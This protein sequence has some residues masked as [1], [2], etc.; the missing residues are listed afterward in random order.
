MSALSPSTRSVQARRNLASAKE[1]SMKLVGYMRVASAEVNPEE[2]FTEHEKYLADY[3]AANGHEVVAHGENAGG[4]D[5]QERPGL[6]MAL[7]QCL[8]DPTCDGLVVVDIAE[9][10]SYVQDLKRILDVLAANKRHFIAVKQEIDTSQSGK[11]SHNKLL[12]HYE[13]LEQDKVVS[14]KSAKSAQ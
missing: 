13:K 14:I 5:L 1:N 4:F 2:T 3:C 11:S 6:Y 8:V 9:I 12:A 7:G 10:S